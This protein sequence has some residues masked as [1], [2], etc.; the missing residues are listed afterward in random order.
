MEGLASGEKRI[1][2]KRNSTTWSGMRFG[3]HIIFSS[4]G[5]NLEFRVVALRVYKGYDCLRR[6]LEAEGLRR[7]LPGVLTIEEGMALY[8][9]YWSEEEI[10]RDGVLA[11][12]IEPL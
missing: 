3:D 2:G 4:G 10:A 6:Y 5:D 11:I 9:Q 7:T 8:R 1:E 12:E